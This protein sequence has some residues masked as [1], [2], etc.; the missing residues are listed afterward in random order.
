MNKL[1]FYRVKCGLSQTELANCVGIKIGRYSH[2]E[3]G[4]RELP[5]VIAKEIGKVLKVD[6]WKLYE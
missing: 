3:T 5:V 4:R 1:K 2:Y 6:W